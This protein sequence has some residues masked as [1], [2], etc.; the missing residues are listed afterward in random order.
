MNIADILEKYGQLIS[1]T[2]IPFIIWGLGILFQ[3]RKSKRDAQLALFLRLIALRKAP[4][5]QEWADCLNQIDVVFQKNSSVRKAWRDYYDALNPRS[6]HFGSNTNSFLLDLLSEMANCLNY[7]SIR[8]TDID[9]Y[10]RPAGL[11]SQEILLK[12]QIRVLSHSKAYSVAFDEN[13]YNNHIY[14]L[15]EQY[16]EINFLV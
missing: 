7:K 4:P 14:K 12:E 5:T 9:R 15:R 13:E 2:L 3:N 10:Y 8:Q 1:I 6:P 16:G 11:S